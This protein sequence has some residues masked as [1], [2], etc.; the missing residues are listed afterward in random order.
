[1]KVFTFHEFCRRVDEKCGGDKSSNR[2]LLDGIIRRYVAD[3]VSDSKKLANLSEYFSYYALPQPEIEKFETL[4]EYEKYEEDN[5]IV[6]LKKKYYQCTEDIETVKGEKVKSIGEL[7]IANYLFMHEIDYEYERKYPFNYFSD[8]IKYGFLDSGIFFSLEQISDIPNHVLVQN[9]IDWEAKRKESK[10]DFYLPKYDIYL[11][12]FGVDENMEATFL[13]GSEKEKYE[14]SMRAKE[15]FHE[16]YGTK[17]I[18]TFYFYLAQDRLL[19]ELEELLRQKE[20]EIGQMPKEE[21]I[22][23]L[24]KN[25][26]INDFENFTKLVKSFINIYESK[27]VEKMDFKEFRKNNNAVDIYDRKRQNLFFNIVEDIYNDYYDENINGTLSHNHEIINALKLIKNKEFKQKYDYIFIDEYQDIN[28]VRCQL[29]QELQKNSGSKIFVVGDDWQSIYRFSGSEV[30]LFIDFHKYFKHPE[31]IVIEE[32]RRNPQK[33]IDVSSQFVVNKSNLKRKKLKYYKK[34]EDNNDGPIKIVKYNKK[35]ILD[36]PEEI[37]NENKIKEY[38]KLNRESKIL[39]LEAIIEYILSNSKD[40]NPEILILGRNNDDIDDYLGNILFIEKTYGNKRKIEYYNKPDLDITFMTVHQSKGLEKDE[41]I[42]LNLEDSYAGFPN[43]MVDDPILSFVKYKDEYE[44]AEERRL[45]Y[46]A[47]TRTKNNVFLLAPVKQSSTF[48][49]ELISDFEIEFSS[50]DFT[51]ISNNKVLFQENDFFKKKIHF[52]TNMVCP[53]CGK[54]IVEVI[55]NNFN[56]E[57]KR[58]KY[59]RCSNCDYDGG[60]YPAS[61]NDVKYVKKCPKCT[62]GVLVRQGDVL[63][64]SLNYH[65][66]CEGEEPL[67]LDEEELKFDYE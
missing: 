18:E 54:G 8:M 63:R 10:P 56:W 6:S 45:F 3:I 17:L 65:E 35:N 11:E 31:T 9:F 53:K 24:I 15:V 7:L 38:K 36:N 48:V 50:K 60:P 43:K 40:K 22:N 46:V 59:V 41:V 28:P 51:Y 42:V 25:K 1:M 67:I 2:Y 66:M 64:C 55:L 26:R 20:V 27:H 58:T 61:L 4:E 47:L 62:R 12:H 23:M 14:M 39:K 49:K 44:F 37:F 29:L 34:D 21:I 13:E 30:G 16:L 5:R 33:L 52:P 57:G 19:K 32:N